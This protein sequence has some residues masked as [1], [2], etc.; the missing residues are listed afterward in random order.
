ML[1]IEVIKH[2]KEERTNSSNYEEIIKEKDVQL[3]NLKNDVSLIHNIQL[4]STK[5]KLNK[6]VRSKDSSPYKNKLNLS[7]GDIEEDLKMESKE[8]L[9]KTLP[10]SKDDEVTVNSLTQY[11]LDAQEEIKIYQ[12][13]IELKDKEIL[14]LKKQLQILAESKGEDDNKMIEKLNRDL[15]IL[16][17]EKKKLQKEIQNYSKKAINSIKEKFKKET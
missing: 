1:L 12:E 16:K 11:L 13:T 17:N 15:E 3:N 8:D 7:D 10:I 2:L 4:K 9:A 5:E 6:L 14:I